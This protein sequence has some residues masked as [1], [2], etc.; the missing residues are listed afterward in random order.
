[1][2]ILDA[3]ILVYTFRA[4][5]QIQHAPARRWLETAMK[6]K[7]TV[8]VPA[9]MELAFLRVATISIDNAPAPDLKDA[10]GFLDALRLQPRYRSIVAGPAHDA[11]F[12]QL[13][14]QSG[15]QGR[16]LTDVWL[17][18]L[19]LEHVATLVS[20]DKGFKRFAGL[21]WLD[22]LADNDNPK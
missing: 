6:G 8:G 7:Q 20:A 12:R 13:C 18:A 2:W 15:L 17:A 3:N 19:A 14:H 11:L 1:M 9:M 22:P 4:D 21:E 10:F 5:M 16:H